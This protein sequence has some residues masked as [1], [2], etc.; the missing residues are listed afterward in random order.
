MAIKAYAS[1]YK[2]KRKI[3]GIFTIITNHVLLAVK[4]TLKLWELQLGENCL[5]FKL[6]I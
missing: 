2:V 3:W 6:K 4:L 1:V 5:L